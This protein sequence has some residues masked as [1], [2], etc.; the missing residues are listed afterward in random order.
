MVN[1]TKLPATEEFQSTLEKTK[2]KN[3]VVDMTNS[4]ILENKNNVKEKRELK[5]SLFVKL[6]M[7]GIPIERKVDL[8]AHNYY[9]T[10]AQTLEDVLCRPTT[11][12]SVR[13]PSMKEH[14]IRT[15]ATGPPSKLLDG[16]SE[17]VLTYEDR[18]GDWMLAGDVPLGSEIF[19][20]DAKYG[21]RI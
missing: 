3:G 17:F 15:E 18:D 11:T 10:L 4:G 1:Q 5:T 6:N 8:N 20:R 7:D 12:I 21:Q 2:S 19:W 13:R 16:S 14:N 9:E